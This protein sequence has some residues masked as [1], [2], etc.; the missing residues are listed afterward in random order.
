MKAA[1]Q[2]ACD[3]CGEELD[4]MTYVQCGGSCERCIGVEYCICG[5]EL[6]YDDGF[7]PAPESLYEDDPKAWDAWSARHPD[8]HPIWH[9]CEDCRS[10]P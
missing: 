4:V 9:L 5:Q 2:V 10:A 3:A 8:N 1:L 7:D 6:D